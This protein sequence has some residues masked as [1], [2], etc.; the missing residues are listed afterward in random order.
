MAL[1]KN[2]KITII[3]S[4]GYIAKNFIRTLQ[5][6]GIEDVLLYDIQD[7]GCGK[8]YEYHR[9]DLRS[10]E[11]IAT[12]DFNCDLLYIF[13]GCTGTSV[14]FERYQQFI[15]VNELGLLNVLNRYRECGSKA[16]IIFPSTRLL[17]RGK[18]GEKIAEGDEKEFK[19]IYAINKYACEQYLAM[20]HNAFNVEY[21]IFR[22]CLPYASMVP[23][24]KSYG[25]IEM[26]LQNALAGKN[27]TVYGD[28]TQRRTLTHIEDLCEILY[29]GATKC[30]SGVYNI[31]GADDFSIKEI[32]EKIAAACGVDVI[33]T[34]W[35]GLSLKLESGDTVFDDT[36]LLNSIGYQYKHRFDEWLKQNM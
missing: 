27:L 29:L 36:K 20:Y 4:N 33:H 2:P 24:G 15:E 11:E 7:E 1:R 21:C 31:G 17:Y 18:N 23:V 10:T 13:A 12:V 16:K 26:F 22:I 32:A 30:K 3:G 28:G 19:T 9:I 34:N 25:T 8:E 5:K 14:G 35:E 6:K